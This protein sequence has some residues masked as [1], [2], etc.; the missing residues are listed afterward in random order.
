MS[1][2][3]GSSKVEMSEP[4]M[5]ENFLLQMPGHVSFSEIRKSNSYPLV[6]RCL[7]ERFYCTFLV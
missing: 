5:A 6:P 4:A 7:D 1:V 3:N 2:V